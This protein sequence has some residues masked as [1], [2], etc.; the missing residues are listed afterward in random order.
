MQTNNI[1][2]QIDILGKN[3]AIYQVFGIYPLDRRYFNTFSLVKAPIQTLYEIS[4]FVSARRFAFDFVV[5]VCVCVTF[6]LLFLIKIVKLSRRIANESKLLTLTFDLYVPMH[7]INETWH[8]K[9]QSGS[10]LWTIFRRTHHL[11]E[12]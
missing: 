5:F 9:T 12:M 1:S 11:W 2:L 8:S 3:W 10:S 7:Q 4:Y 6:L